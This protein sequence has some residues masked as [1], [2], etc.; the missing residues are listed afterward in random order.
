M[1]GIGTARRLARTIGWVGLALSLGCEGF[2]PSAI[3]PLR[4]EPAAD[5][6]YLGDIVTVDENGSVAEAVAVLGGRILLVGGEEQVLAHRG[7]DTEVHDLEGAALLPGFVDP[8]SHFA[9]HG[10]PFSGFANVSRPPV[11]SVTSIPQLIDALKELAERTRKQPGDWIIAYGYE[12]EGLVEAREVT[13]DDLDPHFP[14]NPVVLIHVS[15]HGAVLNSAALARA[16]IDAS[17]P[18]P[19][20]GLIVRKPGSQEPAGLL[21]ETPFFAVMGAMPQPSAVSM[22]E[23]LRPTQLHYAANG[24]TTIQEGAASGEAVELLQHAANEGRLFLDVVAL[25][26][27]QTFTKLMQS[28]EPPVFGKYEG[29][30]KLGGVKS[31]AD[32]SPQ[33]RTA[34]WT[35]P[36]LVPGPG[37]EKDWRGQPIVPQEALDAVFRLAYENDIQTYTHANAD[38]AIDMFLA[39]HQAAGAPEGRRP[40]IIHSQFIRPDQLNAYAR[41]GAVPSFFTNHAF[42]WGDVHVE[43]LGQERAFFLSPLRSATARGIRFTNHTDY[44]VTPLDPLFLMWTATERLSRTGKVIGPEER[45]S[46]AEAL[47]AITIDAA[48]QYFEEDQKGSIEAGKLADFV[49]LDR[50]PLT[51]PSEQLRDIQILETIKEG[52]TVWEV[53]GY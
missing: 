2:S 13:R 44:G 49:I 40:V 11:G 51:T 25:P 35:E 23:A 38:A 3:A 14:D 50:N 16:G 41:I 12:K 27:M 31:V 46:V 1:N 22:L 15:S 19:P 45:I 36:M 17:T 18:T 33:G 6:I 10:V 34:Y 8:H 7:P 53:E 52:E 32:G 21:M 48:Y 26:E 47:R 28:D 20:G 39:A 37:G 30:L 5:A 24:Y 9:L 4:A 29:R 42:F 43:N